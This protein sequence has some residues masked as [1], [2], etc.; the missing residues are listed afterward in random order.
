MARY[1]TE[2][3]RLVSEL[4]EAIG[5]SLGLGRD[6]LRTQMDRR[7]FEM[8]ALNCYPQPHDRVQGVVGLPAHTDYTVTVLL[9]NSAGLEEFDHEAGSWRA[10]PHGPGSLAV[11]VGNYLEV[12]SNGRYRAALHRAVSSSGQ[13][14]GGRRLSIASLPSLAMDERVEVAGDL[15]DEHRPAVYRGS[16]LREFIEFLSAGGKSSE[17]MESLKINGRLG[18]ISN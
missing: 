17:F 4:M 12:V 6:Y 8:M 2:V 16:R 14:G 10:V 3:R 9:A 5:E 13:G 15:V 18:Q 11:H 1:A 7:G